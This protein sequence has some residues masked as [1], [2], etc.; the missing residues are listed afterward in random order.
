MNFEGAKPISIPRYGSSCQW[1]DEVNMPLGLA[2]IARNQR[3]TAQST[4]T[5][6]GH[7]TQL[8]CGRNN[9]LTAGGLLRYLAAQPGTLNLQAVETILIFAYG[10][11]D[12]G[13][14]AC[15]PFIQSAMVLLNDATFTNKSGITVPA[16][17][18][19]VMRQAFNNFFVTLADLL[20]PQ[21]PVLVYNSSD[22]TL[23][24]AS[25]LPFGA[26]WNPGTF[27]RVGQVVSPSTF[28]TFGQTGGQGTWVPTQ[29]GF[30]YQCIQPGTSSAYANNGNP[31][32][33]TTFDGQVAD[34]GVKWQ[35]CTP[36][37]ISGLPDPAAPTTPTTAPDGGSPIANGATVYLAATYLNDKGEGINS[38]IN[39][40]TG[41]IDPTKVL[42]WT[43]NTGGPVDLSIVM[44]GIPSYLGNGGPL[45]SYGATGLNLY[46]FID[47]DSTADPSE[48]VDLSFYARVNAAPLASGASVTISA[49]PAYTQMPQTSTA[50]TTATVGNVDTGL[51]YLTTFFQLNTTYQTGFSNS[52]LIPLNVTQS[53]WPIQCLRLP[54]GPYNCQARVV[55][56]TVAGASAA[57]PFTYISQADIESPGFN[58]PNVQ[59]TSTLVPDNTTTTALF[60]FTDTYLPGATNVTNYFDIIQIPPSVDVYFAKSLQ[61]VVYTGAVGFQSGHLFS[62]IQSPEMVRIPGGNFQVSENDGDRTVCYREIRGIGYSFKE[63][64]GFEVITNGGDPSTWIPRQ[65]WGGNGPAGAQAI[66]IGGQDDS[67]FAVWAH[68][69][70]LYL[71]AGQHPELISRE[72]QDSWNT[73]NW[74][75]GHLIKVKIDQVRRL[76]YVLAPV[77]GAT[78]LNARFVMNYYFGTSD[79]VVFVQRRGILVPNVEGRKWSLDDLLFSDA[80]YIPQKSLNAVQLAGVNVENQMLFFAG[81]GSIKSVVEGQYY[82]EDYDGNPVGFASN[83]IGVLSENPSTSFDKLVGARMWATGSGLMGV[84]AYDDQDNPYPLTGPLNPYLLTAGQ[85]T[86]KDLGMPIQ[87]IFSM[88]WAVG[89]DNGGVPGAWWQVFKSDLMVIPTWPAMPSNASSGDPLPPPYQPGIIVPVGPLPPGLNF[90]DSIVP[91]GLI[92]GINRIFYLPQVPNPPLSLELQLSGIEQSQVV[93]SPL[94][95]DFQL[96]ANRITF[97][98]PPMVGDTLLAW[99]RF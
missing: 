25:D 73:I 24:P 80:V 31:A 21:G 8:Q 4:A 10:S 91:Q 97:T 95:P 41:V 33:P 56:S 19:P 79:P 54:I 99:Y 88:R 59:I 42:S 61:R 11:V 57:G 52:A 94:A 5:R 17:L 60:N 84:T 3:Y 74:D 63:N 34:G 2:R 76:V 6:Y 78:V 58:L 90:A 86:R 39:L 51:R 45:G 16:G 55:A 1:D 48:I 35:E 62:D 14:R 26:A 49:F 82:D 20:L 50:A 30:L 68:R 71:F 92:N 37:F 83:W 9:S 29:T 27:Y 89:M 67:E 40:V 75:F 72:Q 98:V 53:G 87:G 66:D 18:S 32:W 96:V 13:I 38:V 70:G 12:A 28:Q 69:S 64:S 44:P 23:Y 47:T 93:E 22:Q 36:I 46:A 43:N 77:N 85:R 15:P 7:A 81:D 65:T